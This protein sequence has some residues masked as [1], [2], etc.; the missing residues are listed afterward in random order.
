MRNA[1]GLF[2]IGLLTYTWSVVRNGKKNNLKTDVK[3]GSK[4]SIKATK[5]SDH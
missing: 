5:V 1:G 2:V 3:L 4:N